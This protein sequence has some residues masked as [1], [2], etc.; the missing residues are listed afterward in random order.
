MSPILSRN[1]LVSQVASGKAGSDLIEMLLNHE[2][3]LTEEESLEALVYTLQQESTKPRALKRLAEISP[4]VKTTYAEKR[5]CDHRVAYYILVDALNRRDLDTITRIIHN[6][7]LPPEFLEKIALNGSETMLEALLNNQIKL[8]AY[9]QILEKIAA[10]DHAGAFIQSRIREI[11]QDYFQETPA[12]EIPVEAITEEVRE[13][14]ASEVT[15]ETPGEEEE[16]EALEELVQDRSLTTLQRINL[17][18]VSERVKLALT[19]SKGERM[20]L[21]KDSNKMVSQAVVES[22]KIGEEEII[23]IVRNRS[24]GR[25]IIG[26]VAQNR[27]WTKNYNLIVELVNNPKTPVKNALGFIKKLHERDLK[28]LKS[29]KNASPVIRNLAMNFIR[30]RETKKK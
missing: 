29:N 4:A 11:Q 24:V 7:A 6:Q 9:P 15:S 22:P 28:M 27:E 1:P 26:R 8:I 16:E 17:M 25:D 30:Q 13:V 2:L 20:I 12:E 21:I 10:N 23:L 19:G 18:S 14:I 3:P 5:N